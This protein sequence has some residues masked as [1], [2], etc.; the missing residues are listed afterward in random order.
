[1]SFNFICFFFLFF[2][3]L[4][5][6]CD[7]HQ[8]NANYTPIHGPL[9][10]LLL[11]LLLFLALP[12]ATAHFLLDEQK[13]MLNIFSVTIGEMKIVAEVVVV[14][15]VVVVVVEVVVVVVV[16]EEEVIIVVVEVAAEPVVVVVV[17]EIVE[18]EVVEVEVVVVV[19]EVV[20]V[21]LLIM[22]LYIK[23]IM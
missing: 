12:F 10:R 21:L 19:V 4:Q 13:K 14:E 16:E 6:V 3:S 8:T 22:L 5:K 20:V 7:G 11:G 1:M 17:V 2:I 9:R 18:V 23:G 15:V